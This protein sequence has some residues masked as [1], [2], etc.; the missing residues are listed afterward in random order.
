VVKKPLSRQ[1]IGQLGGFAAARELG[2][3]GVRRRGA[4]GGATTAKRGREYYIALAHRRWGRNV[5]VP[6]PRDG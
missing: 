2:V 6:E 1:Q 3:E 4:K 5:N